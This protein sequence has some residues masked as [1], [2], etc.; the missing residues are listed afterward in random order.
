MKK[1]V[2]MTVGNPTKTIILFTLPI[3]L[4]YVFQQ[5]YALADTAI[6]S[7]ALGS[8]AMTGVNVTGPIS[9]LM[10]GFSQGCSSGFG[11]LL[12]QFVGA[13]DEEKMRKSF[14]T[15]IG[16]TI[17]IALFLTAI[18]LFCC[19]PLLNL[20]ETNEQ[21]FDYA[22]DYI[23]AIF[24][25]LV[26]SMFYNLASQILLAFGDS[27]T[28]LYILLISATANLLLDAL[29]FITDW[30][31][32]WA[33]WAT[34][35]SQGL[36][37]VV[38]FMIIF[39]KLPVLRLQKEDFFV[40]GKF[41]LKH[42]GMGLPMAFQF[43]IT[44]IGLMIQQRAFNLFPPVY[45]KAQSAGSKISGIFDG[46]VI[47]AFG[48]TMATYCGQN[49]GTKRLDRIRQGVRSGFI[50]GGGLALFSF[51][52][53]VG[54]A[55]PIASLLMPKE[56]KEVWKYVFQYVLTNASNYFF[57]LLIEFFRLALQGIGRSFI[58]TL[59]GVVELIARTAWCL[60]VGTIS[61]TWACFSNA[62]AWISAGLFLMI[63]FLAV[64]KKEENVNK[65]VCEGVKYEDRTN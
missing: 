32:A 54:S 41:A 52:T 17:V 10:L 50:V 7:L 18:S 2:D 46:G 40:D 4:N 14:A 21:Y 42:L 59:G 6:V 33:G 20:M 63:V 24:S 35:I 23:N 64:L 16:L 1:T 58:A 45:S 27:K 9:F 62:S 5:F 47:R 22:Y 37:A 30:T 51:V 53:A 55:Y 31:V 8:D 29:L 43:S 56:S 15:S 34:V 57:L 36:S 38:G 49:Y 3:I 65:T 26:F 28:P 61:F 25:G 19:K 48:A 60:T 13:K 39:K 44:S 12:S 11:I